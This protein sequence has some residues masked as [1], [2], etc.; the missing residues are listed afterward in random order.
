MVSLQ[1][2]MLE[3]SGLRASQLDSSGYQ[4]GKRNAAL[5]GSRRRG[6]TEKT[7]VWAMDSQDWAALAVD[8][9][10]GEAYITEESGDEL[11][12]REARRQESWQALG[13]Y[14]QYY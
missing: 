4:P 10:E 12:I 13:E 3:A 8:H 5:L 11:A 14:R 1:H 6:I 2:D 9:N 7:M